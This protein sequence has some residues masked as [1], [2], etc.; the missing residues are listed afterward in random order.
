MQRYGFGG[1]IAHKKL[2]HDFR[3]D[4][5]KFIQVYDSEGA[6]TEMVVSVI[7]NLGNWTREHIR[8]TDQELGKFVSS[9]VSASGQSS[10]TPFTLR[11]LRGLLLRHNGVSVQGDQIFAKLHQRRIH[12]RYIKLL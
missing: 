4:V 11:G 7:S 12:L 10:G 1:Y 5:V 3:T 6:S 9:A 2:H 8:A